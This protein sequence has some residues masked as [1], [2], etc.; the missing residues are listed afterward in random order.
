MSDLVVNGGSKL[1]GVHSPAGNKNSTLPIIAAS[2]LTSKPVL[3]SNVPDLVDVEHIIDTMRKLGSKIDWDKDKRTMKIVNDDIGL[4]QF[5]GKFPA[6]MRGAILLMGPLSYRL[7]HIDWK[8]RIGGCTL[9][10]REIDPHLK[11]LKTLGAKV[12]SSNGTI[13]I[14]ASGGFRG[15]NLWM[16][17]MCVTATETFAMVAAVSKGTSKLTNSASEPHVQEL[18]KVLNLMGT[19]VEGIGTSTL[20]I[21]GSKELKGFEYEIESDYHEV[22]TFLA[23]GAMT[24]GKIEVKNVKPENYP[25]IVNSFDKL[26]VK[27]YFKDG[28]AFVDEN[29]KLE[30][31]Q[32]YTSNMLQKIE[33]A[34]WPYV[35]TDLLPLFMA[36]A[37]QTKGEIMFWNKVF[38]GANLWI[39]QLI[40][41]GVKAVLCDPHRV[42]IWGGEKLAPAK[43]DAPD[44][45][46]ATV[47]LFMIAQTIEGESR[48]NNADSIK[49]AHSNFVERLNELGA[50]VRW[51]PSSSR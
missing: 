9:G 25:L 27:V 21:K 5:D 8:S 19:K 42:I 41:F 45:I 23:L 15:G 38:E 47:A 29:Q 36:L 17:Y 44:I 12:D 11:V 3:L 1:S 46:R 24:G 35:S 39:P 7:G 40:R 49:R 37:T 31:K 34:P 13:E 20:S 22:T 51:D 30:I 33:A 18:C 32:P 10:I 48:I 50:D 26:G 6:N 43:V 2:L 16:D 14:D 28:S 4:D